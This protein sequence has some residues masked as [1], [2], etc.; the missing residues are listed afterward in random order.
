[1]ILSWDTFI[2][3]LG[4]RLGNL[5]GNKMNSFPGAFKTSGVQKGLAMPKNPSGSFRDCTQKGGGTSVLTKS[6][7]AGCLRCLWDPWR[8]RT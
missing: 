5:L 6:G 4:G 2:A 1:M 8:L 7:S 3:I